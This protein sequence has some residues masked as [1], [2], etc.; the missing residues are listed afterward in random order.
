MCFQEQEERLQGIHEERQRR[1]EEKAAKEA[2]VEERRKALEAE[3]QE[4]LEKMQERRRRREE[5]IG[6]EQQEKEKE[7]QELA[8][9]KARSVL[10]GP[11]Q[12]RSDFRIRTRS[13]CM[14]C[15]LCSAFCRRA[16][17]VPTGHL[18]DLNTGLRVCRD[19][20]DSSI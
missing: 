1:Q 17:R 15:L 10:R 14:F 9:E 2:A 20:L 7:R 11:M 3:R 4:R 19:H 18:I 16:E 13:G 6:R 12:Y 8:R 5:R